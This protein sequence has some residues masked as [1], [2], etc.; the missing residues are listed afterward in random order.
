[1]QL[2]LKQHGDYS[3]YNVSPALH[4]RFLHI[5]AFNHGLCHTVVFIVEKYLCIS[6]PSWFISMLFQGQLRQGITLNILISK[7]LIFPMISLHYKY[8]GLHYSVLNSHCCFLLKFRNIKQISI[9]LQHSFNLQVWGTKT[10]FKAYG[11]HKSFTF[12]CLL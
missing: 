2:A 9:Y 3:V 8:I 5:Y 12:C 4:V 6:G 11:V 7:F 10:L 1:M